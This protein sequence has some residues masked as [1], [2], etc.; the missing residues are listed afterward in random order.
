MKFEEL[1]DKEFMDFVSSRP[2][3]NFFQTTM[4]RDR[5]EKEGKKTYLVG[6]KNNKKVIAA[7]FIA[8]TPHEFMGKHTYESY[9]GYILDYHDNELLEF[10][11]KS[12]KEFLKDKNALRLIIDPYIVAVSRDM[13]A[14]ETNEVDNT[15]VKE[16]LEKLGYKYNPDG[17][18]VKW[19]YCLDI[20]GKTSDEL[21]SDFRSS[22][23]NNINKTI[24]KFKL[25]IRDLTKEQLSEFKKITED[26]CDRREF[27]DKTLKY[28][29]DMYDVFKDDVVFKI[30]ELN[31]DTYIS[32]MEE[33]NN[34]FKRKIEEL[35][36]SSS[37][38]KKKEE[39]KKQLDANIRKIEEVK[40]LKKEKGN[41]IPLSAA[42]FILYGDEIVYLFSGSYDE[43]MKYCGQYRLQWEIIKYAA[44]NHY[45]R[46]NFYGIQDVFN[47]DGKDYGV[48]EFKKGFGGY[49]EE[50]LGSFILDIDK[51]SK[52][53]NGLKKIK[54]KLKK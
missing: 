41:V 52:I 10:M 4:M 1:T 34:E 45:R 42:M 17:A 44:D 3:N 53:Y 24:T 30:C 33:E 20:N 25:N 28:Y 40:E 12:V 13:D 7:A 5:L 18:Q 32:N 27:Q 19:C 51:K 31:C 8:E 29:E 2:E 35:S 49:V 46:Y 15:S 26:T 14:K 11:T 48:Y 37:N 16:E 9:K 23:R 47:P 21:F 22:T 38:K 36:D 50:L 6:V 43:Y 54:N 39:F